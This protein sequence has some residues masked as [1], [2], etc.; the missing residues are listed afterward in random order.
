MNPAA[1]RRL[2]A[3]NRES[4]E[5]RPQYTTRGG[6]D[7]W[8]GIDTGR[9]R[10]DQEDSEIR[11]L[12][13]DLSSL[14]LKFHDLQ[15]L[16]SRQNVRQYEELDTQMADAFSLTLNLARQLNGEFN[17][18]KSREELASTLKAMESKWDK[19]KDSA[20]T[21]YD[22]VC[23]HSATVTSYLIKLPN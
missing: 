4:T 8:C 3:E 7:S 21:G 15:T 12:S 22:E 16:F 9:H 19:T 13:S 1:T 23:S 6:D 20:K 2:S 14:K 11:R 18:E 17:P 5:V 10:K